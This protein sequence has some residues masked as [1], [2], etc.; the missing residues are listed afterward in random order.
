MVLAYWGEYEALMELI[1][2]GERLS[3]ERWGR[4]GKAGD[5]VEVRTMRQLRENL[6][7][8]WVGFDE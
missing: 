8:L 5:G 1:R 4:G 7:A 3:F 2:K 6:A